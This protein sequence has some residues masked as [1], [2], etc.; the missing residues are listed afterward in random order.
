M[1]TRQAVIL[2][3]VLAI[4]LLYLLI[5]NSTAPKSEVKP[6]PPSPSTENGEPVFRQRLVAVGDLHGDIQNAQKVLRM[7]GLIDSQANWIGGQDILVQTGDIVDRGAHALDIYKL[8]QKLRGQ[9]AGKGGRV[10]SILGNHEI[11]NAIGDWRYVTQDD[12][13]EFGGT[14]RRQEALAKDG[15][16][17]AEWLANYSVTAK[18]PLS[19][20]TH[21]PAL[22]FT[23][24]SL[25]PSFPNLL[26]YPKKINELGYSLL[27]KA[28]TPP[29]VPPYPPNPYS[30]LPKGHTREEAE[31][32]AEGGPLWW[33]GLAEREDEK[34][35]CQ[36]AEELK[37]KLGVRR[38][39]G[40]HTPNFERIVSRCNGSIIIIDT[41]I[42]S[43]YGGVLSALDIVY[44]LTPV[45]DRTEGKDTGHRQDP[46]MIASFDP[47]YGTSAKKADIVKGEAERQIDANENENENTNA[48]AETSALKGRFIE[49]EEVHA[50]Y[51]KRKKLIVVEER[52]ISL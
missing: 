16:L 11:M 17:G 15:W 36:W 19:P 8:M 44:T 4:A 27:S 50:I 2:V 26:P 51:E 31:L 9:A 1:P 20:Y 14:K 7:A 5:S 34:Q 29:L 42:S 46:L 23:H 30:G 33:R 24:G 22:S 12:I 37:T 39:I 47:S 43:A 48:S 40:G 28:L 3:G 38:I 10:L 52:E 21:S 32:Y 35:V 49:R 41:G 25:R 6:H 13:K 45:K 18:V